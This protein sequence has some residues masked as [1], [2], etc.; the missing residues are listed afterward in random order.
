[1]I[2]QDKLDDLTPPNLKKDRERSGTIFPPVPMHFGHRKRTD[3]MN[4][5]DGR[6][7]GLYL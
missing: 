6:G 2:K 7:N 4:G 1:M 3:T 5:T